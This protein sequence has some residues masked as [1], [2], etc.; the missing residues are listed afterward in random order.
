VA[1]S[2]LKYVA[3]VETDFAELP[4]VWCHIGDVNQ[5]VLNLV[6]NAAHAVAAAGKGR[7]TV[8]VR[9]RADADQAVIEVTDSGTGIPPEIADKVFE[10]F[11]TTKDVGTGTGQGLAL[12]WSLVV[13]R[14]GG[15]IDFTTEPGAG[16][17]FTVRLPIAASKDP[18]PG[19]LNT[20]RVE[21]TT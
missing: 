14:H 13:D 11:F 10:A 6:V 19:E 17:T 2:E 21:A 15:A 7:G 20:D 3:D 4:P 1:D 18:E 12:C 16:T 9:T 5:V 8:R